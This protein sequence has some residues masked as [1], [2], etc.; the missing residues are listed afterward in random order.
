MNMKTPEAPTRRIPRPCSASCEVGRTCESTFP[1]QVTDLT[2]SAF[3][4]GH[5]DACGSNLNSTSFH[6]KSPVI[7]LIPLNSTYAV[8][9]KEMLT[10]TTQVPD[11][12]V[13]L[14]RLQ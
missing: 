12:F 13:F 6:Q 2:F 7:P 1:S 3:Y 4:F 11:F 10:F 5:L 8:P 9:P 14:C